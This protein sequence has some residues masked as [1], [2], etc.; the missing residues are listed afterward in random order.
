MSSDAFDVIN[1]LDA[2]ESDPSRESRV[3]G[4]ACGELQVR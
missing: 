4:S 1:G 3:I 2:R